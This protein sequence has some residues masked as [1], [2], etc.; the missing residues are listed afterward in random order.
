MER[1]GTEGR[2]PS[3]RVE[4][5]V[6]GTRRG[7]AHSMIARALLQARVRFELTRRVGRA[8]SRGLQQRAVESQ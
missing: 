2:K 8:L 7:A 3:V 6:V 4:E 1:G 5:R